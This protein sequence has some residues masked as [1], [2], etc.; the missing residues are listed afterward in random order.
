M[1]GAS[2]VA[3]NRHPRAGAGMTPRA[4]NKSL[5]PWGFKATC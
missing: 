3:Y 1:R 5:L 2:A 4:I